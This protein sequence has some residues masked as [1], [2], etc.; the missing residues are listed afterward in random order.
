MPGAFAHLTLVNE[1]R[2]PAQLRAIGLSNPAA[3]ALND[4]FRFTEL[5]AVSPDYPYLAIT[6]R[7]AAAWAD[8]MH[9]ERTGDM[10]QRLIAAV[11]RLDGTSRA[12][13]FACGCRHSLYC[14]VVLLR[15]DAGSP[16]GGEGSRPDAVR[17]GSAERSCGRR[18][19]D[20]AYR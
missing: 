6:E 8:L 17:A 11:I 19:E 1:M 4:W 15:S 2:T 5:G 7:G 10:M 18:R 16:G 12:K 3:A 20:A 9:Y 14:R 13:A